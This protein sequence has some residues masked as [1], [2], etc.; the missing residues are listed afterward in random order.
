MND[1]MNVD[2]TVT[3]IGG[4]LVVRTTSKNL[5]RVKAGIEKELQLQFSTTVDI[6]WDVEPDDTEQYRRWVRGEE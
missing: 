5:P 4:R 3:I 1:Y 6:Q 2:P